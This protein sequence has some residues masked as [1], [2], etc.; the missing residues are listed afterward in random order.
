MNCITHYSYQLKWRKMLKYGNTRYKFFSCKIL[1][2]Q[3]I[4]IKSILQSLKDGLVK[5]LIHFANVIASFITQ[6]K[7]SL[8]QRNNIRH[9]NKPLNRHKILFRNINDWI[10]CI[11]DSFRCQNEN[12]RCIH[13][14]IL[15]KCVCWCNDWLFLS[16]QQIN[17]MDL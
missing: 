15:T 16:V 17:C 5:Q 3:L 6:N 10:R 14:T 8:H 12:I 9:M 7:Y 13:E 2:L 4:G 1:Q 11:N